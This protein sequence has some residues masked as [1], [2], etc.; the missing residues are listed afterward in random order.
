MKRREISFIDLLRLP[1]ESRF[2]GPLVVFAHDLSSEGELTVPN[3]KDLVI[4]LG[5]EVQKI[6][7]DCENGSQLRVK[8]IKDL[9]ISGELVFGGRSSMIELSVNEEVDFSVGNFQLEALEVLQFKA[10]GLSIYGDFLVDDSTLGSKEFLLNNSKIDGNLVFSDCVIQSVKIED[11]FV[12]KSLILEQGSQILKNFSFQGLSKLSSEIS[13]SIIIRKSTQAEKSARLTIEGA[14]VGAV[15]I[16]ADWNCESKFRLRQS[17]V[18]S[19]IFLTNNTFGDLLDLYGSVF[20]GN[21]IFF[22]CDFEGPVVFSDAI[23]HNNLLLT[24]S[25]LSSHLIFRGTSF[26]NNSGLDISTA[27]LPEKVFFQYVE[28]KYFKCSKGE[29]NDAARHEHFK[30]EEIGKAFGISYRNRRDTFRIIKKYAKDNDDL[31]E[32]N[33]FG[34]LEARAATT[35]FRRQ[36]WMPWREN[37]KWPVQNYLIHSLNRWSNN[38]RKSWFRATLFIALMTLLSLILV[39]EASGF[40]IDLILWEEQRIASLGLKLFNPLHGFDIYERLGLEFTSAPKVIAAD[41][42]SRVF[43]GYGYYQFVQAFRRFK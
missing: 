26:I 6:Y 25:E 18:N 15:I 20:Y 5:G 33:H 7:F 19:S 34:Y 14:R 4:E 27:I 29:I 31:Y 43:V 24:F 32:Y 40:G 21:V 28:L 2:E 37:W 9:N 22:K 16:D 23:F 39:L 17:S 10:H 35:M 1:K 36:F 11:V 8:V 3:C 13:G 42:F 12:G 41:I 38:H 30:D